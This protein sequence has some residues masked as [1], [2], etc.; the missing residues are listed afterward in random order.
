[1]FGIIKRNVTF[2]KEKFKMYAYV[3]SIHYFPNFR[4]LDFIKGK[5]VFKVLKDDTYYRFNITK[6]FETGKYLLT[7]YHERKRT[8]SYVFCSESLSHLFQ[9]VYDYVFC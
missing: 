3:K 4:T 5:T 7:L 2:D 1:M 6:V 8:P 9:D